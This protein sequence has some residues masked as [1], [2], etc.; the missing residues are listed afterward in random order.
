MS[1]LYNISNLFAIKENKILS[2]NHG[3]KS[4]HDRV[5]ISDQ[6]LLAI[7]PLWNNRSC[8]QCMNLGA[9]VASHLLSLYRVL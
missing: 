8:F 7:Y 9:A 3:N 2:L 1:Q 6:L 5:Q 4:F